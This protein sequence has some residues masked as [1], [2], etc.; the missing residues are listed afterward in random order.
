VRQPPRSRTQIR[1]GPP[2]EGPANWLVLLL[3][4]SCG[5]TVA[6]LYYAQPL[7]ASISRS[8][9]VSAATAGGLV[10][11]TQAGYVAGML[12]LVPLGDRTDR[13]RLV[14]VLL[15]VA[16]A[17]LVL[18]GLATTFWLL[19]V[20]ALVSGVT[21]VVAQ[22]LLPFAADLAP[23]RT[24]GA[25]VGR[26]VSGL[27][28]GVLLSRTLGSLLADA[29]SWRVVYL[30]SAACMAA[31]A[32]VLRRA[33]PARP[34]AVRL[35]YR[36]LLRSTARLVREYPEL[37]RR[38]LYQAAMFGAF[39]AFWSTISFVLT[40][41][42][43][44]YSQL[45]VGLFALV[46][47]GGALIAPTAGRLSD[48]GLTRPMTAVAFVIASLAFALAGLGRGNVVLL[49]VA[50]VVIDMAVQSSFIF[51]QHAIYRLAPDARTRLNSIYIA[52]FFLG[53]AIGSQAGAIAYHLAG[54]TAVT[55]LGGGLPVL[56]LLAWAVES[57]SPPAI[58]TG[59]ASHP[60]ASRGRRSHGLGQIRVGKPVRARTE[61]EPPGGASGR[62]E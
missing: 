29:T 61:L 39:S 31:L 54:W 19:L 20:G 22:I 41:P 17:A 58:V 14:S 60:S 16:T 23:E 56:A 46:G 32:L 2:G 50:G 59:A 13:R 28:A 42:P 51:G 48:R 6:N 55:V 26:V 38:A 62:A 9:H 24:R 37:R 33:L 49:A 15:V 30:I 57:A 7:L 35:G 25:I 52:T 5:L 34:P 4:I 3:A 43:F 11:V 21:S 45:G 53:G 8:L 18:A 1:L 47:A 12:L 10:T 27:L 40:G 44:R 36:Q